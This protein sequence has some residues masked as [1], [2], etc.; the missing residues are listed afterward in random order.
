ML[1]QMPSAFYD[2]KEPNAAWMLSLS[3]LN[4]SPSSFRGYR[5]VFL[6][7]SLCSSEEQFATTYL[8]ACQEV[9]IDRN[10][11][12]PDVGKSIIFLP[13][14]AWHSELVSDELESESSLGSNDDHSPTPIPSGNY[15][16]YFLGHGA[17]LLGRRTLRFPRFATRMHGR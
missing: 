1:I 8:L 11:S 10:S 17:A 13:A 9:D 5:A 7:V 15:S 4:A 2:Q 14:P 3:V 6:W 16:H 12:I